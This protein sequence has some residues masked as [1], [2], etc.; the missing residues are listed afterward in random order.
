MANATVAERVD[1]GEHENVLP[2]AMA[3]FDDR[4]FADATL[5]L[6]DGRVFRGRA[7]GARATAVA[8]VVF[9]TSMTGYQ[10]ILT[11][12]SY[13]GQLVCLTAPEIGNVGCNPDDDES[14]RAGAAGV[15]VRSL[16][17]VVSNWRASVSLGDFLRQRGLP[18][19]GELDTRALTRHVREHGAICAALS[20]E[21][22][23]DDVL[24]ARAQAAPRMQG[25]A[26]AHRASTPSRY[27]WTQRSYRF[28]GERAVNDTSPLR[29]VAVDYGIKRNILRCLA[30]EG[31]E[32][33]VVPSE[34]PAADIVA[35][36]PDGVLL[37]NGPGDPA[38]LE[39]AVQNVQALLRSHPELPIFGICLG[40]QLLCLALGGT[41]YKLKFG[42]HG[43][44]HP[45]RDEGGRVA[46]T[47]QNHGF[48]VSP[49]L[50]TTLCGTNLFDDTAAAARVADR[51]V[52]G[53]QYH[54][55]ASPG[56]HDARAWFAAFARVM[57]Q[58]RAAQPSRL[59]GH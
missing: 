14:E 17:P 46:I 40:Y 54:P 33:V 56:P 35:L 39:G 16:S 29:A 6:A 38:A 45:V 50:T 3:D 26:L 2:P 41:T 37:S 19:V 12:P 20:T 44:N 28:P 53:V 30:D 7:F 51:P 52:F 23:G 8:E 22:L 1:P 43:G 9:N 27:T 13:L 49:S 10:E 24:I 21:G 4:Y 57:R 55:E 31:I 15:I 47:A 11:D 18:G 48:A 59:S 32:V 25:Q 34:T 5:A 58:R 42:H 36:K